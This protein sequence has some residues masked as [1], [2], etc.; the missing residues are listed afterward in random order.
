M[1]HVFLCAGYAHQE[2]RTRPDNWNKIGTFGSQQ[3]MFANYFL[4]QVKKTVVFRLY[5]VHFQPEIDNVRKKKALMR[6]K[7]EE[8]GPFLFEGTQLSKRDHPSRESNFVVFFPDKPH[9]QWEVKVEYQ[10]DCSESEPVMAQLCNV[11]LRKAQV[12]FIAF[13][14]ILLSP[15]PEDRYPNFNFGPDTSHPW[16][17]WKKKFSSLECRSSNIQSLPNWR[18]VYFDETTSTI[19]SQQLSTGLWGFNCRNHCD[20]VI[21]HQ[22]PQRRL[23]QCVQFVKRM[24]DNQEVSGLRFFLLFGDVKKCFFLIDNKWALQMR[25]VPNPVEVIGRVLPPEE[26]RFQGGQ[27]KPNEQ[28][29]WTMAFRSK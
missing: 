2:L 16:D 6:T 20:D 14:Q 10:R 4:L 3:K 17:K 28:A 12:G 27:V 29:D 24:I 8:L 25:Y 11:L 5:Y 22:Q 1:L 7:Q 9:E 23:G 26:L 21:Q 18:C 19:Q 13:G 15:Q